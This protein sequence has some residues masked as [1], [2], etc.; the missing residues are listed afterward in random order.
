MPH[1]SAT[2]TPIA[3]KNSSTSKGVGAA[4]T[5]TD[6]IWSKPSVSRILDSTFSSSSAWAAA[7]SSGT[8]SPACS[9]LTFLRPTSSA[10]SRPAFLCSSCSPATMASRPALSFSQIRGTAKN[11][12]GR[13]SG[14]YPITWRGSGQSVVVNPIIIGRYWLHWRSAMWA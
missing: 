8:G 13:T 2:G 12:V 3:W 5:F 1:S 6:T 14:M 10:F 9:S 7:S 4:P 11:H